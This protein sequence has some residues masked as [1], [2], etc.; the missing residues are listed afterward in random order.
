MGNQKG[1]R[2]RRKFAKGKKALVICDRGGHSVLL[3]DT[4]I[5]PGTG[6]RVD[7]KWSDGKWNKVDHP[8]NFSA[9]TSE[10]IGLKNPRP[11]RVEPSLNYLRDSDG[12]LILDG[13]GQPI[14]TEE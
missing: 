10:N 8:Q 12:D 11:D 7:K 2:S 14:F 4:V 5:E 13:S 1:R 6:L 3:R 9:D